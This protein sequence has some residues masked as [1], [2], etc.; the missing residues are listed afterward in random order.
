MTG[1]ITILVMMV[2]KDNI[3]VVCKDMPIVRGPIHT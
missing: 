1:V 3:V 2:F